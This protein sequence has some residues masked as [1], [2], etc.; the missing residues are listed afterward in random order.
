MKNVKNNTVFITLSLLKK[1][2]GLWNIP[3]KNVAV[4]LMRSLRLIQG[5]GSTRLEPPEDR[6]RK[7]IS[8]ETTF[9]D[10]SDRAALLGE[11]HYGTGHHS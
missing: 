8:T 11:R 1:M 9:R 5:I 3:L 7:S 4:A 2:P 10:N 6:V